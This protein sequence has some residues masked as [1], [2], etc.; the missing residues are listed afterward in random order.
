M[1]NF[2]NRLSYRI[3]SVIIVTEIVA[4][5]G[6]GIFYINRFS[7]EI[8]ARVQ[9]Q[10]QTPAELMSNEVLKYE[11]AE[12]KATLE[13]IVGDS[14]NSCLAIGANGKIY[15]SLDKTLRD[16][17]IND[18]PEIGNYREFNVE[19]ESPVFKKIYKNGD[20]Y[21]ESIAPIRFSDGKFIG[22]LYIRAKA[23][24]V[25]K[26]KATITWLFIIGSLICVVITS[27][28]IIF[29]F[30]RNIS[31]KITVVTGRINDLSLGK[32]HLSQS[33]DYSKDEIGDLQR[34]IDDVSQKLI[35]IVENIRQG[36]EKVTQSSSRMR[37][38]SLE[39]ATGANQQATSSEEV[40]ST[41]EEIAGNIDQNAEN[42]HKTEKTSDT[43]SDGIIRLT[44]EIESSLNFTKQITEK[45]TIVNDIAF[46]TNLLALNAAVEAARAGEHGRGF[47]VVAS[48]V[49][50]LAEKSKGAADQIIGLSNTCLQ[51]SEKAYSM[52]HRLSPEIQ[53][54][55]TLV[56]EIAASSLEQRN[57]VEQV[58]S[59][60]NDLS[61]IIQ[62][63][64]ILAENMS[65]AAV[66]LEKEANYLK[67]D[68]EF[69]KVVD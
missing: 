4:L 59:A 40:S 61:S 39:V 66:D 31:N 63:N 27:L 29:L 33:A 16:K 48:E 57:G 60:I 30:N 62:K 58:N 15:Y 13:S 6:L 2:F 47:S 5:F 14:I 28:V 20:L 67:S 65:T 42:A 1:Y 18:I 12:N 34:K 55:S 53:H 36:A 17:S 45:I 64:S 32:L 68:I 19:L 50:K 21:Y 69:F 35:R 43:A 49:R 41:M 56:K 54:T 25:V 11:S 22:F 7:K 24:N 26:Q 52:M 9:K 10:I 46:Q 3:G 51:I 37:D 38:I 8:E 44:T 23:E